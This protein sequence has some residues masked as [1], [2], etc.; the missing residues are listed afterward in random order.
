MTQS[1]DFIFFDSGTGGLP[2]M[3]HLKKQNPHARCVYLADTYNFPYGEKTSQEIT[4]S[5][6]A[7]LMLILE[8]F[9]PK[10]IIISCNTLSVEALDFLRKR[11]PDIL[12][13]GTVPAIKTAASVSKN[14]RIGLLATNRTIQSA[15]TKKL[16]TDFA[17]DCTVID[18]G[19]PELISFIENSFF[20][21][22]KEETE[23]AVR[24][25]IDFFR[26]KNADTIVLGC[27]H[28]LHIVDLSIELASPDIHII[29]SC[30]GVVNQALRLVQIDEKN[31]D[32]KSFTYDQT[33]FITGC[34][35]KDDT[36]LQKHY[37]LIAH[38]LGLP[39]GGVLAR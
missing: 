33:F 21:A 35:K 25:A 15:Y 20:E 32:T 24:P 30:A 6:F 27:T 19:D 22:N 31:I 17:D 5:A 29:D 39:Y 10:A 9:T 38:R 23:Q 28:F 18:R 4:Q 12:F 11:F 3:L 1:V 16:I 34:N 14:R 2:Y 13:V 26:S 8:R 7:S 37:E 36:A